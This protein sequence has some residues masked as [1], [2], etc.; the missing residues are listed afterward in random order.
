MFYCFYKYMDFIS[1]DQILCKIFFKKTHS[2]A[3][4]FQPREIVSNLARLTAVWELKF[5]CFYCSPGG[6]RTHNP[7]WETGLKP[8]VYRQFHHRTIITIMS[9]NLKQKTPLF[10]K[11]GSKY[12]MYE[13]LHPLL[14]SCLS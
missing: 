5:M 13:I 2:S 1:I 9:K 10:W 11:R 3:F 6:T 14:E 8:V 4:Y 12:Y 7:Q